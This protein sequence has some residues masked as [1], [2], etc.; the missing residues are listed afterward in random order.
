M[1][2][3]NGAGHVGRRFVAEDAATLRPPTEVTDVWLNALQEEIVSI[4]E[5]EGGVLD[6]NNN[7]QMLDKL[8]SLFLRKS[9]G[10]LTGAITQK[11][12][13]LYWQGA[14]VGGAFVRKYADVETATV[15]GIKVGTV[16]N[17]AVNPVTGAWAGRDI[18]DI[19]FLEKWYGTAGSKEIW[20]APAAAAGVAPEWTKIL[21]FNATT[22]NLAIS[23]TMTVA[24]A[25]SAAHA[26]QLAQAQALTPA[27]KFISFGG[28]TAP[29]GFLQCPTAATNVSRTTYAE[30]F[31]A[32]GTTWGAGDG[33]TTFGL[34]W[35][36]AGY[37]LV[38]GT[39]GVQ[40]VGAN[41]SHTHIDAGH[42]HM[43]NNSNN[44]VVGGTNTGGPSSGP[45]GGSTTSTAAAAA[46]IQASG[47][48][49]NY[50]AGVGVM[51][52]VKY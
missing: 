25:T 8:L 52:C 9:G 10:D 28:T 46:N 19:C 38:N 37:T 18:A 2:R 12:S 26:I 42:A 7:G 11:F 32:I 40:T 44:G 39:V 31:A 5:F 29:P 13:G 24:P 45:N 30:L 50:A 51:I 49:A 14:P 22:G 47:G 1:D 35:F 43:Q 33:A 36:P 17:C 4:V 21:N 41:I 34:P 3:I 23:G 15:G 27:G 6:P 20:V 16:Y 48:S